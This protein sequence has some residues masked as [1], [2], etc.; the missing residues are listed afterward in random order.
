MDGLT[1][2]DYAMG[3]GYVPFLQQPKPPNL[4]LAKLLQGSGATVQLAKI[5]NWPPVG[6]PIGYEATIWPLE[7]SD[8]YRA[9]STQ[10]PPMYPPG[11]SPPEAAPAV[12]KAR[13]GPP[14]IAQ[15]QSATR[16]AANAQ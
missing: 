1:A 9:A 5:P 4:Q 10:Y 14:R 13:S 11:K 12:A 16:A 2:L 15:A 3:R 8:G 7:P 6:P